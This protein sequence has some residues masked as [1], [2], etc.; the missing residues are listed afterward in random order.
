MQLYGH[1]LHLCLHP[2][3]VRLLQDTAAVPCI[4]MPTSYGIGHLAARPKKSVWTD[5]DSVQS[6]WTMR[7]VLKRHGP[8]MAFYCK[9]MLYDMNYT[10]YSVGVT[11]GDLSDSV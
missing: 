2:V 9:I 11:R 3:C 6:V 5:K 1:L 4:A 10:Y 7:H 8:F